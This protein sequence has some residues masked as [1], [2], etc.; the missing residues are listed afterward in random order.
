MTV[1]GN[2]CLMA[3]QRWGSGRKSVPHGL[4][5]MGQRKEIHAPRLPT[6]GQQK[7]VR[8]SRLANDGTAEG[9][10]CL[11]ACQRWGT[12]NWEIPNMQ[13]CRLYYDMLRNGKHIYKWYQSNLKGKWN[14][15]CST[16]HCTQQNLITTVWQSCSLFH[17]LTQSTDIIQ[18]YILQCVLWY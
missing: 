15:S 13:K 2:P 1:E 5:M 6:M 12:V 11:M 17:I 14:I 10:P 16:R 4:P 8:A 7:E 9:N 18:N 3:R